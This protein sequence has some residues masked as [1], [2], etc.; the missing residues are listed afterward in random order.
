MA[1]K[2]GVYKLNDYID[3]TLEGQTDTVDNVWIFP[4]NNGAEF[5]YV[6]GTV[7]AAP[8]AT[9][10][11][12]TFENKRHILVDLYTPTMSTDSQYQYKGSWGHHTAIGS[13]VIYS[14]NIEYKDEEQY[15]MQ[16][17][18]QSQTHVVSSLQVEPIGGV[19]IHDAS[20]LTSNLK[21]TFGRDVGF[22]TVSTGISAV[23]AGFSEGWVYDANNSP[24]GPIYGDLDIPAFRGSLNSEVNLIKQ[25]DLPHTTRFAGN[26]ARIIDDEGHHFGSFIAVNEAEGKMAIGAENFHGDTGRVYVMNTDGTGIKSCVAPGPMTASG[27]YSVYSTRSGYDEGLGHKLAIGGGKV[28]VG[29]RLTD[30]YWPSNG[31]DRFKD[32]GG[33]HVYD[34]NGTLLHTINSP[35]YPVASSPNYGLSGSQGHFGQNVY[36][37]RDNSTLYVM[38][39]KNTSGGTRGGRVFRFN[40]SNYSYLGVFDDDSLNSTNALNY[41]FGEYITELNNGKLAMGLYTTSATD[42]IYI[43]DPDGSNMVKL[44]IPYYYEPDDATYNMEV[45]AKS[46]YYNSSNQKT[47]L[48]ANKYPTFYTEGSYLVEGHV[49]AGNTF[50]VDSYLIQRDPPGGTSYTY[51]THLKTKQVGITSNRVFISHGGRR[52]NF[53]YEVYTYPDPSVGFDIEVYPII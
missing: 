45:Y 21:A 23:G 34:Y 30:E 50:V 24:A 22:N 43:C 20:K 25:P 19:A 5:K 29:A 11:A 33:V 37:S 13:T 51:R 38:D 27:P 46:V 15:E 12:P 17:H 3:R 35:D 18:W 44:E 14:S 32:V 52:H 8:A 28:F 2:R 10:P 53:D 7:T 26:H 41:Y 16:W 47:Y 4:D 36:L 9:P 1:D 42:H 49:G 31:N 40:A 39:R 48:L 6:D